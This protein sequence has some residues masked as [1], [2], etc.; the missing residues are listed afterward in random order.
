[1][2]QNTNN[3]LFEQGMDTASIIIAGCDKY[4]E[5]QIYACPLGAT[6]AK[7]VAYV[8]SGLWTWL[9]LYLWIY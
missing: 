5:G 4:G 6:V 3:M 2:H 9:K 1:M 7:R 8:L